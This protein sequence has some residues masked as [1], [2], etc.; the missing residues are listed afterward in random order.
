MKKPALVIL[1]IGAL[2]ALS[3]EEE[4]EVVAP[5]RTIIHAGMEGTSRVAFDS[6]GKFSWSSGDEIAVLTS[7]GSFKAFSIISGEGTSKADFAAD[8][9]PSETVGTLAVYPASSIVS[10]SGN[11]LKINLASEHNL[12]FYLDLV[13]KAREH[14]AAGDFTQWKDQA[15]RKLD[16]RL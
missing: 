9:D 11:V 12:A 7:S 1:A 16:Q 4:Q 8:L 15:V 2:F 14:I 6:E 13:A 3:C 10:L 5:G